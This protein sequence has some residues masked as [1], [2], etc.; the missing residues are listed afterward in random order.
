MP[1]KVIVYNHQHKARKGARR[2]TITQVG[3]KKKARPLRTNGVFRYMRKRNVTESLANDSNLCR[4]KSQVYDKSKAKTK[5]QAI[6]HGED[7][8]VKRP[9]ILKILVLLLWRADFLHLLGG[10]L[11]FPPPLDSSLDFPP[12]SS[13]G[14]VYLLISLSPL[15]LCILPVLPVSS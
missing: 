13:R 5:D 9:K 6:C 11:Y 14:G 2:Y 12:F 8:Y 4:K 10:S 7:P 1:I 15:S 3:K